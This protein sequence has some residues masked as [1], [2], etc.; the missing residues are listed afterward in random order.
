[1]TLCLI[2]PFIS[3]H[4]LVSPKDGTSAGRRALIAESDCPLAARSWAQNCGIFRRRSHCA[5][6][7]PRMVGR[8]GG[9]IRPV[10]A[11]GGSVG[12]WGT[13]ALLPGAAGAVY[14][15]WRLPSRRPCAPS[16]A[17]PLWPPRRPSRTSG[18][19]LSYLC[20]WLDGVAYFF[21]CYYYRRG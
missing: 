16:P 20:F 3:A 17:S 7:T 11:R 13:P 12:R 5:P 14:A 18:G 21:P 1:M 4:N 6:V 9:R 8:S 2:M 15:R 10:P 19:R